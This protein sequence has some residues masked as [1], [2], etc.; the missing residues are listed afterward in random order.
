MGPHTVALPKEQWFPSFKD[1]AGLFGIKIRYSPLNI[2]FLLAIAASVFVWF[3]VWKTRW[4]YEMRAVAIIRKQ[5][6]MQ[7]YL[8]IKI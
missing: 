5:L 8:H 4:G 3:L 1:F 2:S 7:A 6:F